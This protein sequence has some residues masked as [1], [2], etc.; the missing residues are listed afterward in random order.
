MKNFNKSFLFLLHVVVD[1]FIGTFKLLFD[2]VVPLFKFFCELFLTIWNIFLHFFHFFFS[3]SCFFTPWKKE[4]FVLRKFLKRTEKIIFCFCFTEI[5]YFL[6]FPSNK[7][8]RKQGLS[9]NAYSCVNMTS[10]YTIAGNKHK[11]FYVNFWP[12]FR[13]T[14]RWRYLSKR[15]KFFTPCYSKNKRLVNLLP[16]IFI[17]FP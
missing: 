10:L 6:S 3:F 9:A 2:T 5:L 1:R 16:T 15:M 13:S 14:F 11:V 8:A 12:V 4:F 17:F 7:N